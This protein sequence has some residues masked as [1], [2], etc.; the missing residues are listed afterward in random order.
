MGEGDHG[1]AVRGWLR[2]IEVFAGPLPEFEPE[3]APA[4]PVRLFLSWLSDA[5]A[6]GLRDPHAMTLSTVDEA[7]DPDARVLILKGVDGAGWQFAGHGFSPKG[8]QLAVHPRAALTFYWP[9]HGRQVR[10]RGP[11]TPGSAQDNATDFLGRSDSARAE[12]LLARQS[13]Y[14]ADP[15]ERDQA[16]EKALALIRQEPSL[17]DSGWTLYTL[18]PTEV[19]FWQAARS[20][21][22]TRLRYERAGDA[23]ERFRLWS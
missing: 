5:V 13:Q 16:L 17:V 2:G 9:G 20:R 10:L 19:E 4:D 7:G 22:H 15:A 21:V 3:R 14:L 12:S 18:A 11:V 6:D 23:W 1:S 8:H